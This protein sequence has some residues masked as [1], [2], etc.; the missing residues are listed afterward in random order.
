MASRKAKVAEPIFL[1]GLRTVA[2]RV[3]FRLAWTATSSAWCFQFVRARFACGLEGSKAVDVV[4]IDGYAFNTSPAFFACLVRFVG[5]I[6]GD[7]LSS[8]TERA[9]FRAA[10]HT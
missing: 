2:G 10:L 7:R 5:Y 9:G 6:T 3:F 4:R 8:G 1:A